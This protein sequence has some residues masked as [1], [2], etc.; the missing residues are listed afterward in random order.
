MGG[1]M[2]GRPVAI[3]TLKLQ[4][5]SGQGPGIAD[6]RIGRSRYHQRERHIGASFAHIEQR[7]IVGTGM[8][9]AVIAG[10]NEISGDGRGRDR[11]GLL[12]RP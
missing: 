3:Q 6:G 2:E 12:R 11:T 7:P 10:E 8:H 4:H 1:Q 5:V 9:H